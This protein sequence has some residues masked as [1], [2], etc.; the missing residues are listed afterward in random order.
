MTLYAKYLNHRTIDD[1][2]VLNDGVRP[3]TTTDNSTVFIYSDDPD[4]YN[5]II[6]RDEFEAKYIWLRR[7]PN[8]NAVSLR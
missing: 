8:D 7:Y 3:E 2:T 4:D 6:D 5:N 1:I